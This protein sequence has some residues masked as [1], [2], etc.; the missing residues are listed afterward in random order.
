MTITYDEIFALIEANDKALCQYNKTRRALE[1]AMREAREGHNPQPGE[2]WR[3]TLPWNSFVEGVIPAIKT[4]TGWVT[5]PGYFGEYDIDDGYK[6]ESAVIP[7]GC[8]AEAPN[9]NQKENK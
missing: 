2:A 6:P 3:V 7:L 1:K 9:T 4:A 5:D 8:L